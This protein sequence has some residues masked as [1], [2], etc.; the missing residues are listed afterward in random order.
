MIDLM[1]TVVAYIFVFGSG[2]LGAF[3]FQHLIKDAS[4]NLL[5]FLELYPETWVMDND[6]NYSSR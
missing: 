1:I 6:L 2:L 3:F 4:S 5:V